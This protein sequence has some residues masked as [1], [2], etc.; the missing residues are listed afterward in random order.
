MLW[1]DWKSVVQ[2]KSYGSWNLHDILPKD[3]DFFVMTASISGLMGHVSQ[4]HYSAGNTY[5]DALARY[6]IAN[7]LPAVALN[8]GLLADDGFLS[9]NSSLLN[10][11]I[12]TGSYLPLTQ[13]ETLAVFDNYC[14]T[15]LGI[16]P[17]DEAQ[18]I[19]GVKNPTTILN[20]GFELPPTMQQPLWNLLNRAQERA[21][22]EKS[23][24]ELT[25]EGILSATVHRCQ[26]VSA[27]ADTI[28]E[29]FLERVCDTLAVAREGVDKNARI[30]TW[31]VVSLTALDL[32]SWIN[33]ALGVYVAAFDILSGTTFI[34]ISSIATKKCES[35]K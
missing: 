16:L 11:L 23:V 14:D 13:K 17:I 1:D 31:G 30:Y 19:V 3:I 5:Q 4:V 29:A 24:S 33:R 8:L 2:S 25:T 27:K 10:R 6:R 26:T 21:L 12:K 20:E 22:Q 15:N 18:P 34:N 7:G 35:K 32:R 9:E 28:A